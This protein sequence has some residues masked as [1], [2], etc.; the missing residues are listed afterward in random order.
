MSCHG[1]TSRFANGALK[2]WRVFRERALELAR[3][4][5]DA[6]FER[7]VAGVTDRAWEHILEENFFTPENAVER[8]WG[9]YQSDVVA[10][11]RSE[12]TR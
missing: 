6:A 1:A 9:F 11:R 2:D 8:L 5:G 12:K 7:Y 4:K 3:A 10:F